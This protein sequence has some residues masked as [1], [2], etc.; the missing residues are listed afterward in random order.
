[1][2][3]IRNSLLC[4][5]AA[6]A[7]LATAHQVVA[8]STP[9]LLA[10]APAQGQAQAPAAKPFTTEQLDQMLAPIA[11]YPDALLAQVMMA[12]TYP[13]EVVEAARWSKANPNLKGDAAVKAVQDKGWDVSVKSLVA[14]P[15]VVQQMSDQLEWTQKLG[16]AMLAQHTEV[17]GSIQRLRKRAYD[18][19]NLKTTPQQTVTVEPAP[20][21]GGATQQTIVIKP[22]DPTVVYVP[23]YQPVVTYGPWPYPSY[24]P[25]YYP[26]YPGYGYGAALATGF[27]W[28]AAIAGG[29]SFYGGWGW[30]SG[31]VNVDIDRAVNIDRNVNRS[32]Y[33][34]GNWNHSPEHRKGVAYR[35]NATR[36]Q[37]GKATQGADARQQFRGKDVQSMATGAGQRQGAGAGVGGQQRPGGTAGVGGGAQ[38]RPG[39]SA[40]VGGGAQQ[41]PAAT[42]Q[43]Q[44]AQNQGAFQGM[45]R[46]G[47]SMN[48]EISRGQSSF[49]SAGGGSRAGGGGRSG[50]GGGRR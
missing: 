17:A 5:V 27:I 8:R 42:Q 28:G 29:G 35:D 19:Q 40:G 13:L 1:M 2:K 39:G 49:G 4:G 11:L 33:Q 26:P 22:T 3:A 14:F 38:Q 48:R 47:Q 32:N 36:Q 12:S 44:G 23:V 50:G 21:A 16:D 43:R 31:N 30:N 18:A 6:V 24:P 10:Q 9:T 25:Y 20:A 46:G 37:Y 45:D 7:L 41:R 15:S 34:G